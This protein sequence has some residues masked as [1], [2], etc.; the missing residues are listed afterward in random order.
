MK[1]GAFPIGITEPTLNVI[2]SQLLRRRGLNALG[3]VIIHGK[4]KKPDVLLTVNGVRIIIEGKFE[5]SWAATAL[6]KQCLERIEEGLCEICVGV[7]YPKFVSETLIPDQ[8]QLEGQLI[9]AKL[10]A[11]VAW[12]SSP[13]VKDIGWN[14]VSIAQLADLITSSYTTLV[15]EDIL[16]EAINSLSLA[17]QNAAD[18][19]TASVELGLLAEKMGQAMEIPQAADNEAEEE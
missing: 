14:Q 16:G 8:K 18:K 6:E 17:L 7:Q 15:T 1:Q 2:L 13:Q 11:Y 10:Q 3:E 5:A 19:L 9:K 12:L 4:G